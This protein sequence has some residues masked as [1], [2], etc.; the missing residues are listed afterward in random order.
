MRPVTVAAVEAAT[1]TRQTGFAAPIVTNTSPNPVSYFGSAL[2]SLSPVTIAILGLLAVVAIVGVVAHHYR[3]KL[4][5][6][7]KKSWRVHHGLYTFFGMLALGVL[8]IV[9]TG[10]G[11]I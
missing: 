2:E 11:T 9:A 8:I 7:W 3:A 5:K 4:P 6:T 10:G 1:S